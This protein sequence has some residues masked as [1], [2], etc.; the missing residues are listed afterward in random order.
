MTNKLNSCSLW[1]HSHWAMS[2]ILIFISTEICLISR[3]HFRGLLIEI[4]CEFVS[5]RT[6]RKHSTNNKGKKR[7]FVPFTIGFWVQVRPL[8]AATKERKLHVVSWL[9]FL[10]RAPGFRL[11][12]HVCVVRYHQY[13][14]PQS[15]PVSNQTHRC[16]MT[17]S[18]I[19]LTGHFRQKT[20]ALLRIVAHLIV[21]FHMTSWRPYLCPKTMKRRPCF[22]P[23]PVLWELNSFLM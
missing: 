10:K 17:S 11:V 18:Y 19:P 7:K 1:T 20:S 22:C 9:L 8:T 12:R 4:S 5:P 13:T 3:F 14:S 15:P 16:S 21:C 2:I 23:K 6:V